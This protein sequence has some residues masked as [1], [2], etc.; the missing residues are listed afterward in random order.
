MN[1]EGTP[2]KCQLCGFIIPWDRYLTHRKACKLRMVGER[3]I[4]SRLDGF[5]RQ[6]QRKEPTTQG[7]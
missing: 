6:G 4:L 1:Q 3:T 7:E 2:L 5:V